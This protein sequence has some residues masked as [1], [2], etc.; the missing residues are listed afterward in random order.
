MTSKIVPSNHWRAINFKNDKYLSLLKYHLELRVKL[1]LVMPCDRDSNT[2]T[3]LSL[4]RQCSLPR[5]VTTRGLR[6]MLTLQKTDQCS[7][8]K[9][10]NSAFPL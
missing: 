3:P 7:R 6:A 9:D 4:L 10:W 5:V 8:H 2:V 1:S